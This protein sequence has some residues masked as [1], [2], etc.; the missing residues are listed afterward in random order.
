MPA[1]GS[2]GSSTHARA[3]PEDLTA[4]QPCL[5]GELEAILQAGTKGGSLDQCEQGSDL[6]TRLLT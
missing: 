5:L 3:Q 4:G 1:P 6:L 2:P